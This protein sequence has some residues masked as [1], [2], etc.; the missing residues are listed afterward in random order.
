VREQ[1]KAEVE[2]EEIDYDGDDPEILEEINQAKEERKVR[3]MARRDAKKDS[4][5]M[6]TLK[7]K[8]LSVEYELEEIEEERDTEQI[9][10]GGDPKP[11]KIVIKYRRRVEEDPRFDRLKRKYATLVPKSVDEIE[12]DPQ[13]AAMKRKFKNLYYEDDS[14]KEVVAAKKPRKNQPDHQKT[15]EI[16]AAMAESES[17]IETPELE[18]AAPPPPPPDQDKSDEIVAAMGGSETI[19]ETPSFEELQAEVREEVEEALIDEVK[20]ELQK[21]MLADVR[22]EL[23]NDLSDEV[24]E[25]LED[26]L[27][28][29]IEEELRAELE[30]SVTEKLQQDLEQS[31]T[32]KLQRDLEG[33][34]KDDLRND[35]REE[36]EKELREVM[37]D[38]IEKT[39]REQLADEIKDELRE[40]MSYRYKKEIEGQLRREVERKI[41]RQNA[42]RERDIALNAPTEKSQ[43]PAYRELEED[44]TLYPI[45][46]GQII[47]LNNIYFDANEA[48]L[49]NESNTELTRAVKFLSSNPN[50][51][52]EISGH[53][54]GLCS[55]EF[56]NELSTYRSATVASYLA[57]KGVSK[58]RLS[59]KGYGK[60]RPIADNKSAE[61]R[62]KNQRVEMKI[63]EIK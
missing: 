63:L 13:L 37:R 33:G 29:D 32:E 26:D 17:T 58:T 11:E 21:E 43:T 40:E 38:D 35:L 48:T 57:N 15:D 36:I 42:E 50:L 56:A 6:E 19:A 8:L 12:D 27:K 3:R 62:R 39:L 52:V 5:E 60:T 4:P 30:Q 59:S 46:V 24:R 45:E 55:H 14:E 53:T 49:K 47:P 28:D 10:S 23:E 44:I 54:N 41:R 2:H 51:I 7:R 25:Q 34:V 16:I 31:V 18:E 1:T 61:G 20:L 9:S 22:S